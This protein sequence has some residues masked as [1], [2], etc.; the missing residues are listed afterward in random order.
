ME[1]KSIQCTIE[2]E[3]GATPADKRM[4]KKRKKKVEKHKVRHF[5]SF[6]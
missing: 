2:E 4:E 5:F 3:D 6:Y 1:R